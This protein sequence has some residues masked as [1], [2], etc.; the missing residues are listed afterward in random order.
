MLSFMLLSY[1][2]CS[3]IIIEE[4]KEMQ[5]EQKPEETKEVMMDIPTT[6]LEKRS[7]NKRDDTDTPE[8]KRRSTPVEHNEFSFPGNLDTINENREG[9]EK[10]EKKTTTH[11]RA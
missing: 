10:K 9:S 5:E 8:S 1:M 11:T 7:A 6:P 4:E 3:T 2:F